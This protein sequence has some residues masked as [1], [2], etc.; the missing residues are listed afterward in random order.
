MTLSKVSVVTSGEVSLCSADKQRGSGLGP[1]EC[2]HQKFSHQQ[3]PLQPQRPDSSGYSNGDHYIDIKIKAP[4]KL[5]PKQLALL[6][7]YA[8]IE[9][10]DLL[11]RQG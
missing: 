11:C 5:D 3:L 2:Q 4:K 10:K 7:A 1:G 8:E 9:R 6:Q